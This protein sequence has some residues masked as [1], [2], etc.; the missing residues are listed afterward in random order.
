MYQ[1]AGGHAYGSVYPGPIGAI[2]TPQLLGMEHKNANT[3]PFASS[4]CGACYEACPVKINIPEVLAYLRGKTVKNPVE[5]TAFRAAFWVMADH[6]RFSAALKGRR[7]GVSIASGLGLVKGWTDSR[8]M[9]E[10][11]A[12]SFRTWWSKRGQ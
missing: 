1:R 2:L 9:P 12:E 11:P 10:V 8:E 5:S 6:R 7:L 4:M 3:L